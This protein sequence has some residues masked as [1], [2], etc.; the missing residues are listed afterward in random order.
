ME[1]GAPG[2]IFGFKLTCWR[3]GHGWNC[4]ESVLARERSCY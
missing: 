2:Q 4:F 3:L 1:C